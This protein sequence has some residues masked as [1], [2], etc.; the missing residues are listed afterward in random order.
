MPKKDPRF[1]ALIALLL[2]Q[3]GI[4][5]AELSRLSGVREGQI[6][7]FLS[8]ERVPT[9]ETLEKLLK[10]AGKRWAWLDRNLQLPAGKGK[11]RK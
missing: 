9:V 11:K 7:L 8:S 3:T 2:K 4:K 10:A 5:P 6:S 1:S